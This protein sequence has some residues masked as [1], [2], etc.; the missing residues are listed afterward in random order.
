MNAARAGGLS[1]ARHFEGVERVTHDKRRFQHALERCSGHRIQIEVQVVGPV[2]VVA[3]RVPGIQI[4]AAE[5]DH[6]KQ[7]GQ[8]LDHRKVDHIPGTVLDGTDSI[9]SGRGDGARFMKKKSPA[10]PFG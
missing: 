5:I 3:A 8:I 2:D 6:P 4:D 7:R 10:T 9:Q 1:I